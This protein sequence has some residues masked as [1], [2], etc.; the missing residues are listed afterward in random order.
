VQSAQSC[1][2]VGEVDFFATPVIRDALAY[3]NVI[4]NPLEA[5]IYLNRIMKL[6]GIT[7]VNVQRL[8]GEARH[9]SWDDD[10]SDCVYECMCNGRLLLETQRDELSEITRCI[11]H[12]LAY[13][14]RTSISELI[15]DVTVRQELAQ[16]AAAQQAPRNRE[17]VRI[18]YK[19]AHAFR[20]SRL[21]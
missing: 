7:E 9:R 18:D 20:F 13:K 14:E 4:E 11:D 3:L 16:H 19:G 10:T 21:P 15:Y 12:I 2:I 5:G 1:E 6:C 17:R 8:N